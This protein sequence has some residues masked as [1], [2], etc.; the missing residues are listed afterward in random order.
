MNL[1]PFM[2][3]VP[4]PILMN[5]LP[6]NMLIIR[7]NRVYVPLFY[8][9]STEKT[10]FDLKSCRWN[11]LGPYLLL[12]T[13]ERIRR[14]VALNRSLNCFLKPGYA[15]YTYCVIS[16]ALAHNLGDALKKKDDSRNAGHRRTWAS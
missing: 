16:E 8:S 14:V 6:D 10:S 4:T 7:R 12:L 9:I 3:A 11:L 1:V 15:R 2:H 13:P 5:V